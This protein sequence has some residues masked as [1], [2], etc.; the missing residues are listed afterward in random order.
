MQ[1]RKVVLPEPDAPM[2]TTV[3]RRFT[4]RFTPLRT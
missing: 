2:I 1:R 4:V 3:S